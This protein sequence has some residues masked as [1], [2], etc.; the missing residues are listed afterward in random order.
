MNVPDPRDGGDVVNLQTLNRKILS[1]IEVNNLLEA[2][3]YLRLDGENKMIANLQTNNNRIVGLGNPVESTDGVNKRS[4]D[5]AVNSVVKGMT[6]ENKRYVDQL[7]LATNE[8]VNLKVMLLDGTKQPTEDISWNNH[9][10][11]GLQEPTG[12]KDAVTKN[13]VDSLFNN[14]RD[15]I[16][17][18]RGVV[19]N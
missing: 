16:N 18:G 2:L 11:T 19:P 5:A 17:G 4:L 3:K 7:I 1:E 15:I 13:Y 9:K 10:I 12:T 6:A 8:N 14:L